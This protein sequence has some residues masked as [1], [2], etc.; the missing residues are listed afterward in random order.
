[1][2]KR[3]LRIL[4]I[5][6]VILAVLGGVYFIGSG[7]N[8]REDVVLIDYAAPPDENEMTITVGVA[9]SAGYTRTYKNVSD[10]PNFFKLQFYYAFCWVETGVQTCDMSV[11]DVPSECEKICFYRHG[12]FEQMLYRDAATNKWMWAE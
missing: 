3:H 4:V 5:C 8:I 6:G 2:R 12:T 10:Y 9:S 11:L 7:F 1:M